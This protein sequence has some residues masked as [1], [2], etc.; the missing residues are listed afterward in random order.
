MR[1]RDLVTLI[2]GTALV[3]PLAAAAQQPS[4][5][6]IGFLNSRSP[7]DT[8]HLLAGFR[9][10]LAENGYVEGQTVAIEY[11]WAMGQYERLP[12]LATEL[13]RQNVAV[14]VATGG[15]PVGVAAKA[16]TS[17]I[18]IVFVVSGDPAKLGLAASLSHPG[19]NSTGVAIFTSDIGTKR[20]GLLRELVP[21]AAKIGFLSNPAFPTAETQLNDVED[22]ARRLG[23]AIEVYRASTEAE[24]DSAFNTISQQRP[25]GLI[26]AADPFFD[27][28]RVQLVILA[29]RHAVPAMYQLREYVAA[30]GLISYGIDLPD[31]Y[32]QMGS[33]AGKI[34]KGIKPADLPV[35]RPT[36][37]ELVI[38]LQTAKTLGLTVPQSILGI[39]EE[40]IE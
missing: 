7:G 10:G 14:L 20:L 19:G 35:V 24:I 8:A 3:W 36:R 11:R 31:V 2:G 32:R 40:V 16:A 30:G 12:A 13:V 27:T 37:F 25:G 4:M 23:V 33:Y 9:K 6:V 21:Q 22:G 1:R 18:P 34:L 17:T 15:E 5:P 28:R 29:A 26:V 39:A 38:N